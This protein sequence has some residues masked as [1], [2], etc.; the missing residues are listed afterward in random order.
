MASDGKRSLTRGLTSLIEM[1]PATDASETTADEDPKTRPTVEPL[2]PPT[3]GKFGSRQ[4]EIGI[5]RLSRFFGVLLLLVVGFVAGARIA[6]VRLVALAPL[7]MFT[8]AAAAAAT[9]LTTDVS[10][11]EL[12]VRIGRPRWHLAAALSVLALVGAALAIAV[13]APGVAFDA[14]TDPT[15]GISLPPGAL[16]AVALVA[17][18]FGV[19]V[20]VNALFA[21]GEELGWR[22]YLLW[23][24]APLGFW[25]ASAAV[26]A[27]WGVWHAPVIL[28]GY[29]YPSFPLVGVVAMTAATVAFSPLYTYF[30]V[31]ARSVL[32][33]GFFHGVFNASAGTLL[34]Y[35]AASDPVLAEL[36]ASPVG[37]AGVVAFALGTAFV[38]VRKDPRLD[39]EALSPDSDGNG[40]ASERRRDD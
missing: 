21:L 2:G 4:D 40:A 35:T 19:G 1:D 24:L 38:A 36:V 13:A 11:R 8:P 17:L 23:E 34:A 5:S 26:G 3:N 32:A 39:R 12:G 18:T 6:D 9:V 29:N 20:T 22:G 16:G 14:S 37:L 33:A 25:R 7:Y 15:P 31:R 27:V 28:D 10:I 30:V